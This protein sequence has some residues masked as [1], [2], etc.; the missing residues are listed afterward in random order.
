MDESVSAEFDLA[1]QKAVEKHFK[2]KLDGALAAVKAIESAIKIAGDYALEIGQAYADMPDERAP[3]TARRTSSPFLLRHVAELEIAIKKMRSSYFPE[4]VLDDGG[5]NIMLD[6]FVQQ[7]RGREVSISSACM[8]SRVPPTTALR[9]IDILEAERI[10]VR[11]NDP[12]DR[13]RR[14][15]RLTDKAYQA[16]SEYLQWVAVTRYRAQD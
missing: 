8:A 13:R 5:W 16:M 15:V 7:Q 9:W 10:I 12:G 1:D 4:T 6:L 2:S 11:E 14:F 3:T